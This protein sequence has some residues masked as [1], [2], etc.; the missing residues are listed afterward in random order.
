[1]GCMRD[2]HCLKL[3]KPKVIK[4]VELAHLTVH[5]QRLIMISRKQRILRGS[6]G[7]SK[8]IE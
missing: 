8:F 3:L 6:G 5:H 2:V 1:M 7:S 4:T